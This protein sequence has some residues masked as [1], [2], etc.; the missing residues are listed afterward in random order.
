MD[1]PIWL[2]CCHLISLKLLKKSL[3][4]YI[5]WYN[6][7]SLN[8]LGSWLQIWS[9]KSKFKMNDPIWLLCRYK[10]SIKLM[11]IS[12]KYILIHA[13]KDVITGKN[14]GWRMKKKDI[15]RVGGLLQMWFCKID[16]F[17]LHFSNLERVRNIPLKGINEIL[18][19]SVCPRASN[20]AARRFLT[21]CFCNWL[22]YLK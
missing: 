16:L 10:I 4:L 14:N 20:T 9:R 1:D 3:F 22:T 18:I 13:K 6:L 21:L 11:V 8:F 19:N 12:M 7:I 17:F 5:F 2:Q 15:K